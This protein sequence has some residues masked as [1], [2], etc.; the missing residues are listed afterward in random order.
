MRKKHVIFRNWMERET[1]SS[2]VEIDLNGQ[3]APE[4]LFERFPSS[5]QLSRSNLM[6]LKRTFNSSNRLAILV[7]LFNFPLVKNIKSLQLLE[8]G[9]VTRHKIPFVFLK[10]N[11]K[12]K[13]G[14]NNKFGSET[15]L[16][17]KLNAAMFMRWNLL[18][19][20]CLFAFVAWFTFETLET[21]HAGDLCWSEC[22]K[23]N[24]NSAK[25]WR[26][27]KNTVYKPILNVLLEV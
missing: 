11:T 9:L 20:T 25:R 16:F 2:R 7:S 26:K 6:D 19:S 1:V 18:E 10:P 21:P 15:V 4:K 14:L 13:S 3:C 5:C 22:C 24:K 23:C 12:R 17:H 27:E 8:S